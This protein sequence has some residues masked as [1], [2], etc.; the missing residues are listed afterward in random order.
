MSVESIAIKSRNPVSYRHET[1]P[2]I[3][4]LRVGGVEN[5]CAGGWRILQGYYD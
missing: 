2:D 3:L 1:W 5:Y 4:G